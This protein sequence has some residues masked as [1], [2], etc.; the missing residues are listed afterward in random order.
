VVPK[1]IDTNHN[2]VAKRIRRTVLQMLASSNA[3]HLGPNMSVI[4][5][6]IAMYSSVDL[7]L[8]KNHDSSRSRVVISKGHCAAA[9]YAVL[10]EFELLPKKLLEDYH[11]DNSFLAG[12]VSHMVPFVEHS[13]GA[14]GHGINVAVGCAIGL[15]S[16]GF[17]N[18]K[19]LTLVGDGEIQEGSVW[20]AL[21]L[22]GHM[23]LPNFVLLVDNNQISSICRTREVINLEPFSSKFEAFG[24]LTYEVDGHSIDKICAAIGKI[25]LSSRPGV[26]ICNTI[27]G[28]GIK[29][30]ENDP[31]W[32][33]RKLNHDLLTQALADL[34]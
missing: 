10:S 11:K 13:T 32:H 14:L 7:D 18:S 6:L 22:A 20:E 21:M 31:E 16:R 34:A 30:A 17:N 15:R 1:S 12:H 23:Q 3:S 24:L 9:T 28:K 8:I 33:Y 25:G 5:I 27:K 19:V 2:E 4:E 26:V 29:F